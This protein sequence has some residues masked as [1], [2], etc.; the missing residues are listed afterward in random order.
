MILRG[1]LS[2]RPP[3]SLR[4]GRGAGCS[5]PHEPAPPLTVRGPSAGGGGREGAALIKRSRGGRSAGVGRPLPTAPDLPRPRTVGGGA[6]G[7]A[8]GEEP[9]ARAHT[10]RLLP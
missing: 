9:D 8:P 10:R 7:S 1:S 5:R 2:S 6:R 4:A 3:P